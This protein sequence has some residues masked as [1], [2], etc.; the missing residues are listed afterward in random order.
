[1]LTKKNIEE[2]SE[3]LNQVVGCAY[4]NI[5]REIYRQGVRDGERRRR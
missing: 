4:P 3:R 2:Y 5:I 1:M